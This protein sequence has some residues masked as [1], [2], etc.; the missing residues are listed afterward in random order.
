MLAVWAG[1][2]AT[3]L[4][5][6]AVSLPFADNF[7]DRGEI[8][9]TAGRVTT[10]NSGATREIG[11]PKHAD[12]RTLATIW[13]SWV[14]PA[15]GILNLNTRNSDFQTVIGLYAN[16]DA[17]QNSGTPEALNAY[18]MAQLSA[19]AA[20]STDSIDR[21]TVQASFPVQRGVRYDIAL[22]GLGTAQGDISF[23]WR[24]KPSSRGLP[25]V[26]SY[27]K[28][29]RSQQGDRVDLS[30][31]VRYPG[32]LRFQWLLNGQEI[33]GATASRL[34]IK[35][36]TPANVGTY[37]L[38][39]Q[40]P[41][42]SAQD[43]PLTLS[44]KGVD[45]QMSGGDSLPTLA[46]DSLEGILA[47]T[48][49]AIPDN[50]NSENDRK[51]GKAYDLPA[52]PASGLTRAYSGFQVFSSLNSI[53]DPAE[54][55]HCGI[56][57]GASYWNSYTPAVSGT[58]TFNTRG[59]SFNTILAIYTYNAAIGG[60]AGLVPVACNN[61]APGF[62]TSEVTFQA[63]GGVKY[64]VVVDGV[65]AARGT[66]YLNYYYTPAPPVVQNPPVSQSVNQGASATFS[67]SAPGYYA[68]T[69]QWR[70]NGVPITGATGTSYTVS[71]AAA[72]NAGR[73][74]V[75]VKNVGGTTMSAPANL[76]VLQTAALSVSGAPKSSVALYA[77]GVGVSCPTLAGITY[78]LQYRTSLTSGSWQTLQTRVGTGFVITFTTPPTTGL[79]VFRIVTQ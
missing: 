20:L 25:S 52:I 56:Y 49:D 31:D 23:S 70:F 65:N 72:A 40:V 36:L 43:A 54:P 41:A 10:S 30:Y 69:Y 47:E 74:D 78:A 34:T 13:V 68:Q 7:A 66:I 9:D 24:L 75:L 33:V 8:T 21:R 4:V 27:S 19:V 22:A 15:D 29:T 12:S 6:A 50:S 35:N 46:M 1:I 16:R 18:G 11:E 44:T 77:D 71:N 79:C 51:A 39:I 37:V 3:G 67:V 14:A 55:L 64:L 73:Y 59:S 48:N 53:P 63:V 57:G 28:R 2:A 38:Q 32:D 26:S 62:L 76:T 60:Y 42:Q 58:M 61:D 5:G 17:T 45:V